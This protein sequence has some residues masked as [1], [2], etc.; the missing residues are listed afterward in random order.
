MTGDTA[1]SICII[2]D[3]EAI[4]DS[5]K[6]VLALTDWGVETF[7][8]ARDFLDRFDPARAGCVVADVRMPGM[9]GLELQSL[10]A[11]RCPGTPV[12]VMTGHGDIAMAVSAMKAGAVDFIEKPFEIDALIDRIRQALEI[13]ARNRREP[14]V[15]AAEVRDRVERLTARERDVLR[16]LTAGQPNKVIAYELGISPRTVEIHRARVMDKMEVQN[17]SQIVRLILGAGLDPL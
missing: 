2:D 11:E 10:L 17:V 6:T 14:A 12:I 1:T 9:D 4:R 8:S 15:P 7:G 16:H 3:D 5:L 13:G